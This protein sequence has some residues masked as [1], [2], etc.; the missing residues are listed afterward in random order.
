MNLAGSVKNTIKQGDGSYFVESD[1]G[2]VTFIKNGKTTAF[3]FVRFYDNARFKNKDI[4]VFADEIFYKDTEDF[5]V[6]MGGVKIINESNSELN[7]EFFLYNKVTGLAKFFNNAAVAIL[8]EDFVRVVEDFKL[9]IQKYD[10]K[11][12][13]NR[14]KIVIN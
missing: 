5:L 3:D 10:A 8:D 6:A 13:Q 12:P 9:N 4:N 11:Q 14:A 1:N 2:I 7:A